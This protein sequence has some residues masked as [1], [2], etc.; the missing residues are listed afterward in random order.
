MTKIIEKENELKRK[1]TP[2]ED[3]EIPKEYLT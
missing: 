3:M 1:M 2:H